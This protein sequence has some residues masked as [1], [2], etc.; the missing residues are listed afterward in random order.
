[1]V[2]VRGRNTDDFKK[3]GYKM[4]VVPGHVGELLVLGHLN[5]TISNLQHFK[6]GQN[7]PH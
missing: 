1:M 7:K 2:D 5:Q 3:L 6:V 4:E